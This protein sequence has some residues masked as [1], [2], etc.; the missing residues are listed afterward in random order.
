MYPRLFENLSCRPLTSNSQM[1]T[2]VCLSSAEI[3]DIHHMGNL[4]CILCY[5]INMRSWGQGIK[6]V[7]VFL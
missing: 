3:K 6:R 4:D 7:Y 1:F 2:C 5:D